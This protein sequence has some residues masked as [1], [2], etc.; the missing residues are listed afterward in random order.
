MIDDAHAT[1]VLGND[2]RGTADYYGLKDDIDFTVGTL[3]KALGAEGGFVATS[4]IAKNYLLSNARSFIFQTA[5]S[6]SAIEAAREGISIVQSE[7]ERRAQL[8]ENAQYVRLQLAQ[9]GFVVKGG[10]TPIISLIIG[11]SHEA[12]QFSEKLMDEGIFI[13][14]IRPPTVPQGSSRLRITVMATHT[15]GQLNKVISKIKKI[16]REM[17]II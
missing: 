7:P 11:G 1:G 3:S 13:P 6:P 12:M 10:E 4:S 16:G 8:L 15:I 2:G 5:L 17:G 14:A 9:C